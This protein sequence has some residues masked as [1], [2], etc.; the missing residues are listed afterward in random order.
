MSDK[1]QQDEVMAG[2]EYDGIQEMDNPLPK[3]WLYGFYLCI[4]FAFLYTGYYHYGPG[5]SLNE[6][7]LQGIAPIIAGREAAAQSGVDSAALLAAV[8]DPAR[9]EAGKAVFMTNCANCHGEQGQGIV[10]PNLTDKFW[11]HGHTPE[12]VFLTIKNGV[13]DKG[14]LTWGG[15]LKDEEMMSLVAFIES[16]RG[17]TPAGAKEPQG[18][19]EDGAAAPQPAGATVP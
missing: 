11:L 10:G 14:M 16:I 3:W 19:P 18:D 8:A 2:H 1:N 7:Y 17:T 5:V 12:K 13:P 4:V 6:A 9:K 15:I